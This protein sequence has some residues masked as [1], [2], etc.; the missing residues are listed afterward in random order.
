MVSSPLQPRPPRSLRPLR[1][2]LPVLWR[3]FWI[4]LPPL[5]L[6]LVLLLRSL[7]SALQLVAISVVC[8]AGAGGLFWGGLAIAIGSAVLLLVP[9]LRPAVDPQAAAEGPNG[10]SR[11]RHPVMAY[12]VEKLRT[13]VS[14]EG[15][16]RALLRSGWPAS[17]VDVALSQAHAVIDPAGPAAGGGEVHGR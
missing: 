4:G 3:A 7:A 1:F 5:L 17:D 8:T 12:A 14:E 11:D 6:I 10:S 2:N 9:A 15:V 13:G 16:R